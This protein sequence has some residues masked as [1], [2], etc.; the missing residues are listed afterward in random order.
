MRF[1]ELLDDNKEAKKLRSERLPEGWKDIKQVFH[2]QDLFYVPKVIYSELI[3]KHHD[4]PLAGY[5]DIEKTQKLI[6]R[7]YYWSTL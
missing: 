5:L 2:F 1:L 4:N 3:N 6:A 7:K